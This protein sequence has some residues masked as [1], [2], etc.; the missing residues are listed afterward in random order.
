MTVGH[1]RTAYSGSEL[2]IEALEEILKE[3]GHEATSQLQ[4]FV[5]VVVPVVDEG[6]VYHCIQHPPNHEGNVCHLPAMK[7]RSGS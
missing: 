5:A 1:A 6:L 3:Q 4:P 2:S 7:A